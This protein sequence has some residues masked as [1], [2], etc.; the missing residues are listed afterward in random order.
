MA[1]LLKVYAKE[2]NVIV[3]GLMEELT[4]LH[5]SAIKI[6]LIMDNVWKEYANAIHNILDKIVIS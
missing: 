3:L 1:I 5:C 2:E 4:V 6:A